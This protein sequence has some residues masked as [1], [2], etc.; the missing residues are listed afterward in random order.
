MKKLRKTQ[1]DIL[2]YIV[3]LCEKNNLE[4]FLCG[5]T[6]LGAVR[7]KGYIPWDDDLDI[8]MPR[9][10]YEKFISIFNNNDKY[11]LDTYGMNRNYWLP[12]IKVRNKNTF[13]IESL[14]KDYSGN[15]GIWVDIFPL[16]NGNSE[17]SIFQKFQFRM[18][19]ILR[20][21]ISLKVGIKISNLNF[22]KKVLCFIFRIFSV[23]F[24][25]KLQRKIMMFN[26][27]DNS[28]YFINLGSQY[29]YKK[30]THLKE[31]YYPVK[32]ISFEGKK[33]N[34]P[35]DYD[36]VLTKIYGKNYMQLPP[37]EK[38][39]TH[40]PLKIIFE[41]GEEVVFDEKI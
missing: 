32:K 11:I 31:K 14:Q 26:L 22:I 9:K 13:C 21:S 4:Y 7:H 38:R 30:Q 17:E 10:D 15:N 36:Y 39:V 6:L 29:G 16:D 5:G 8:A 37:V 18:V 24:L 28:K 27:D 25:H 20:A 19:S 41:D 2:D 23:K 34:V 1:I 35:N 12:F 3:S 40:N 33:Y